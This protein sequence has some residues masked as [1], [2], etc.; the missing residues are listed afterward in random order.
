[1]V[2]LGHHSEIPGQNPVYVVPSLENKISQIS[3]WIN[4]QYLY[5]DTAVYTRVKNEQQNYINQE[6]IMLLPLCSTAQARHLRM[7]L[8]QKYTAQIKYKEC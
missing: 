7:G 1:M 2:T 3:C 5:T 4:L 6:H 8:M